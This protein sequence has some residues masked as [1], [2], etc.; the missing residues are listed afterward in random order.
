MNNDQNK[1]NT[2]VISLRSLGT[3]KVTLLDSEVPEVYA[4]MPSTSPSLCGNGVDFRGIGGANLND[5]SACP[6]MS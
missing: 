6:A 2:Q 3:I 4:K 5:D 1:K